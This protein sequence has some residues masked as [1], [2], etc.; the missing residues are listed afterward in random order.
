MV[1]GNKM[2]G[3][4][5]KQR[6]QELERRLA[7]SE[8]RAAKAE[9]CFNT[10]EDWCRTAL[11]RVEN[12]LARRDGGCSVEDVV[13]A[14]KY[15]FID[16][17]EPQ[18]STA[19][20]GMQEPRSGDEVAVIHHEIGLRENLCAHACFVLNLIESSPAPMLALDNLGRI[21]DVNRAVEDVTGLSRDKLLG[22]N[23]SGYFVDEHKAAELYRQVYVE[24]MVRNF[25]LS[26]LHRN[27]N[28]LEVACDASLYRNEAGDAEGVF[29]V[30]HD[31]TEIKLYESQMLFQAHFDALT[32][33]P[34]RLLFRDRL[35]KALARA[36][37]NGLMMGVLFID[38]DNF[39]DIND[40]L[41]HFIGDD[42]L[43]AMAIRLQSALRE[44]DTIARMGGDEFAILV[45]DVAD[46]HDID[47]VAA[48][49]LNEVVASLKVGEHEV[50]VSCSIGIT[51]YPIDNSDNS[52]ADGLLRN[53]DTA[54]YRAKEEG[55]NNYR[56][57]TIEMNSAIQQ[58]VDIGNRLR[59]AINVNGTEF[60]LHYQPRVELASGEITGV[61]ALLRWNAAGIGPISPVEFIP[62]AEKNG[63]IV[64]IG[65]WVLQQACRQA[66]LWQEEFGRRVPVAVN[67]SARQFRDIDVAQSIVR[68]LD[69]T[70][71]S[72]D[73]LELELTESMLMNDPNRV[74]HTLDI[75]KDIGVRLAVDDF[76]TGYCS[77]SYLKGFPLDYLKVDRSFVTDIPGDQN[78]KTL[79]RA[80][81]IIAHNLGL[82]VIAEGVETRD[83]LDFLLTQDCDEIQGYY[84]SKPLPADRITEMLKEGRRLDIVDSSYF[85]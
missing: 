46:M 36:R 22:S 32:A 9:L 4:D 1:M 3:N 35:D 52:D 15:P 84:F 2:S 62:V 81:I 53:A 74:L 29:V 17:Q 82:K 8:N 49:I 70:G 13:D 61:E 80:I 58:R 7:K 65:E 63:T 59:R 78:D 43:K 54:M 57:F 48:K 67:L 6:I 18:L 10:L 41:G 33:L 50:V 12:V 76:G 28:F 64:Q 38:L 40:T 77:L 47:M 44:S 69:Q 55:K 26:I 72:P 21:V 75:L 34:N 85:R 56:H 14:V 19:N 68:V 66:K 39:Q 23:F 42:V 45:E 51:L 71:L 24:E 83:Q 73:L 60:M 16:M 27:G 11:V 31:I 20:H 5:D 25:H 30:A 37:R 79:V